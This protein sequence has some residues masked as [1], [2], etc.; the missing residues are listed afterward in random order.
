M[1][2]RPTTDT[3]RALARSSP[4]RWSSVEVFVDRGT[5]EHAWIRRP[6][7]LRVESEGRPVQTVDGA[8]PMTGRVQYSSS[9]RSVPV[10]R[11]WPTDLQPVLDS[12]GLVAVR[13]EGFA[14][15][16]DEPFHDDYFWTALFDP[17]E[18]ADGVEIRAVTEVDRHGRAT[19]EA[20]VR[21]TPAYEP[22]CGCCALLAG[23]ETLDDRPWV[24]TVDSVVRLDVQTGICVSVRHVGTGWSGQEAELRIVGVDRPMA[25]ELFRP[26]TLLDRIRS[27]R[28]P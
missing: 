13:P 24:P 9:G 15:D 1:T 25:D 5:S 17:A 22:R 6:D 19:W 20:T 26:G 11:V 3:F 28:R 14:G 4:W 23:D 12:D 10:T 8:R 7:R 21:P 16:Y 18:L 2:L 27:R